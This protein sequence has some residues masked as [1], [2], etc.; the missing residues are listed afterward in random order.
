MPKDHAIDIAI[1]VDCNDVDSSVNTIKSMIKTN[2][3]S[4]LN[5]HLLSFSWEKIGTEFEGIAGDNISVDY[6]LIDKTQIDR[7]NTHKGIS[8]NSFSVLLPTLFANLSNILFVSNKMLFLKNWEG[9]I[10][11]LGESYAKVVPKKTKSAITRRLQINYETYFGSGLILF[12]LNKLRGIDFINSLSELIKQDPEM[13]YEQ[14]L[15]VLLNQKVI[16]SSINYNYPYEDNHQT[17]KDLNGDIIGLNC[18]KKIVANR[19]YPVISEQLELLTGKQI[20]YTSYEYPSRIIPAQYFGKIDLTIVINAA[21]CEKQS[22]LSRTLDSVFYQT[23]RP[24]QIICRLSKPDRLLEEIIMEYPKC[25]IFYDSSYNIENDHVV[26]LNGGDR[27]YQGAIF[28]IKEQLKTKK[29]IITDFVHPTLSFDSKYFDGKPNNNSEWDSILFNLKGLT[30]AFFCSSFFNHSEDLAAEICHRSFNQNNCIYVNIK[31]FYYKQCGSPQTVRYSLLDQRDNDNETLI[32][33]IIPIFNGATYLKDS[34][35]SLL[36]QTIIKQCEIIC[37]DDCSDDNSLESLIEFSRSKGILIINCSDNYGPGV[38]RNVGFT[39]SK[40][41]YLMYLDADDIFDR[42]LLEKMYSAAIEFSSD[43]VICKSDELDDKTKEIKYNES[44]YKTW[45]LNGVPNPFSPQDVQKYI[46]NFVNSWA[47]DKIYSRNLIES[48]SLHFENARRNQDMAFSCMS[49]VHSERIFFIDEV[50]I[51]HRKNVVT[52][53]ERKGALYPYTVF[54][55][56]SSWKQYLHDSN[57]F[58]KYYQSYVNRAIAAIA[59]SIKMCK[60]N[61]E[62]YA[63]LIVSLRSHYLKELCIDVDN[64]SLYYNYSKSNLKYIRTLRDA[65]LIDIITGK[66]NDKN[67][68]SVNIPYIELKNLRKLIDKQVIVSLTTYPARIDTI[69]I[70]LKSLLKQTYKAD[71]I[72]LWLA[73]EQFQNKEKDL[74]KSL[75]NLSK[76]IKICWCDDLK[77][78]K[79]YYYTFKQHPD[80]IVITVDDDIIYNERTVETLLRSYASFPSCVSTIRANRITFDDS[81]KI[82]KYKSWEREVK[83]SVGT[84]SMDLLATGVGGV[85]YP[86]H[87]FDQNVFDKEKI[88]NLALYAD[89]LWLKVNELI[90]KIPVVLATSEISLVTISGTQESALYISNLQMGN[91]DVQLSNIMNEFKSY[92][93][94]RAIRN[95]RISNTSPPLYYNRKWKSILVPTSNPLSLR[96]LVKKMLTLRR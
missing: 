33:I 22:E 92:T 41:K 37:I 89:D 11:E 20:R 30:P 93:I 81:G 34:L 75:L 96:K 1:P 66:N 16:R 62:L 53:Q 42:H 84:P 14:A 51:T 76:K 72:I 69:S 50:L 74:P 9:F 88:I 2:P 43:V 19:Y 13:D 3:D 70:V 52:S 63:E 90:N 7:L 5:F 24:S 21:K 38:A 80:S 71:L 48:H 44:M 86:P 4:K 58:N 23:Y 25:S 46:F 77:P 54:E 17:D 29:N 95:N 31:A 15:N 56:I 85:L 65:P 87:I 8:Y 64:E 78:H 57:S 27:L 18:N 40:G 49:L 47:W 32:S 39:Y 45:M 83:D 94:A 73:S 60:T 79:K 12:D 82:A 67:N 59:Y 35:G 36:D 28:C 55:V 68:T 91:N 6:N 10:E 26:F 61:P